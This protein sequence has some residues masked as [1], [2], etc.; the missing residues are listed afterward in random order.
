MGDGAVEL[1]M[2][3]NIGKVLSG[4]YGYIREEIAAIDLDDLPRRDYHRNPFLTFHRCAPF[5]SFK[6]FD[7]LEEKQF[8]CLS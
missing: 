6:P 5:Q 7:E 4:E 8:S 3:V 2:V 1:D